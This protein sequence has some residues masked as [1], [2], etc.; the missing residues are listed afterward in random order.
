MHISNLALLRLLLE[1]QFLVSPP[2]A[3]PQKTLAAAPYQL[4]IP[5]QKPTCETNGRDQLLRQMH[6]YP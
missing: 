4:P 3:P 2:Q 1:S 5:G 6:R